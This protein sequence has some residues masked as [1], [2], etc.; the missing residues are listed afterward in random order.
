MR[1]RPIYREMLPSRATWRNQSKCIVC[2]N[3]FSYPREKNKGMKAPT[4]K[5]FC[6]DCKPGK[7]KRK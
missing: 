1:Y 3:L 2:K 6:Q 5:K 4:L 7:E